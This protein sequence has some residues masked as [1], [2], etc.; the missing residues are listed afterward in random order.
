MHTGEA[1]VRS[2]ATGPALFS[3]TL[4]S[5]CAIIGYAVEGALLTAVNLSSKIA[6]INLMLAAPAAKCVESFSS[7]AENR[8][9]WELVKPL[10]ASGLGRQT[11]PASFR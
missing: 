2:M 8:R 10:G 11:A 1:Q 3:G 5:N 7:N 6:P 9:V 4:S